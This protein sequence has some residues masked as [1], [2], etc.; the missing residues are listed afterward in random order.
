[1]LTQ[2]KIQSFENLLKNKGKEGFYTYLVGSGIML[3]AKIKNPDIEYLNLSD[4]FFCLYRKS[5]NEIYFIIAKALRKSAHIL[6]RHFLKI[7]KDK[8]V[9]ARFLNMVK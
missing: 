1:M 4:Q 5:G 7:N 3:A 8:E 2:E 9:N 6:Y